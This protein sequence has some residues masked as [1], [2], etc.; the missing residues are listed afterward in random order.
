MPR[1]TRRNTPSTNRLM[2]ALTLPSEDRRTVL[3]SFWLVFTLISGTGLW[4]VGGWFH[5]P[6]SLIIG[7]IGGACCGLLVFVNQE[8]VRRLY[9]AWNRRLVRPFVDLASRAV[10][11]ICFFIIFLATGS[12]G[13]RIRLRGYA[14]TTWQ[15]RSSLPGHAY[16]LLFASQGELSARVGWV[17]S[18]LYW[19]VR[20]G[21]AWSISL[22]PFLWFL[23]LLSGEKEKALETNIYTLF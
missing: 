15:F 9:R 13:S 16:E 5:V 10:M 8:F 7:L 12:A 3:R 18:Y 4:L 17:R 20:S 19:A 23:R 22:I 2:I 6:F 14:A 11:G 21:N 1:P